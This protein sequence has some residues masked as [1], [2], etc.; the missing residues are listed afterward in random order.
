MGTWFSLP[1]LIL[2]RLAQVAILFGAV[3]L[4]G[5]CGGM[6]QGATGSE[7]EV[8]G[9]HLGL[10]ADE[11]A[12]ILQAAG[13][14]VE[15]HTKTINWLET[16]TLP[17]WLTASRTDASAHSIE[18]VKV[19]L[20][21]PPSE[22]VV[23][24]VYRG[25]SFD[26]RA[27]PLANGYFD[28][29]RDAAGFEIYRRLYTGGRPAEQFIHWRA[30]GKRVSGFGKL[31]SNLPS[32]RPTLDPCVEN[33]HVVPEVLLGADASD[34]LRRADFATSTVGWGNPSGF[35][36]PRSACGI[37]FESRVIQDGAGLAR[38]VGLLLLDQSTM[39]ANTMEYRDWLRDGSAV[40]AKARR[41]GAP[42]A[43]L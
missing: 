43:V 26:D 36:V 42:D 38:K 41:A 18:Y 31:L 25:I 17:I 35:F 32:S 5:L 14:D 10:G 30:D 3:V 29:A 40:D 9:L 15:R 22:P 34:R 16:A 28:A 21:Y 4:P 1:Q 6:A 19:W 24:G 11:A 37:T 13:Y 8:A 7:F 12:K 20:S 39:V 2:V 33:Y 23:L 27:G